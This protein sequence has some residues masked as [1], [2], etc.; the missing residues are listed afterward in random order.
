MFT[1]R[2]EQKLVLPHVVELTLV[3]AGCRLYE[4]LFNNKPDKHL[5][6]NNIATVVLP[7]NWHHSPDRTTGERAV[8]QG[9]G[10]GL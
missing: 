7:A 2:G 5:D 6:Y 4:C 8:W 10:G 3:A 9:Q 1:G